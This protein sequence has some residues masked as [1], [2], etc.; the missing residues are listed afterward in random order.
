MQ[1]FEKSS[2]HGF[3][4]LGLNMRFFQPLAHTVSNA[5]E[6]SFLNLWFIITIFLLVIAGLATYIY[7]NYYLPNYE[8]KDLNGDRIREMMEFRNRQ[9][10]RE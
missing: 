1:D 5:F 2:L 3:W 10:V 6:W 4:P 9:Q 7:Q 8:V